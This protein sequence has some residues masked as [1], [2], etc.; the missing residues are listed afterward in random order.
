M[1]QAIPIGYAACPHLFLPPTIAELLVMNP[2]SAP[3]P[4]LERLA[5]GRC[6]AFKLPTICEQGTLMS[7]IEYFTSHPGI[8]IGINGIREEILRILQNEQY[9]I[10][11]M[12]KRGVALVALTPADATSKT[13]EEFRYKA[14]PRPGCTGEYNRLTLSFSR[15]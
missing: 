12:D 7:V 9:T 5:S 4:E 1:N 3:I 2:G 15:I 11:P 6:F 10:Q 14:T 13:V 8:G